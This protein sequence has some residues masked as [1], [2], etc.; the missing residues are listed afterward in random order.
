[1]AP[2]VKNIVFWDMAPCGLGDSLKVGARQYSSETSVYVYQTARPHI[3]E[4]SNP[5][6]SVGL[7]M[8]FRR[9]EWKLLNPKRDGGLKCTAE[10]P[11]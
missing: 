3:S 1:M 10:A 2:S 11:S 8:R 4:D 9:D 6:M 7:C 5:K